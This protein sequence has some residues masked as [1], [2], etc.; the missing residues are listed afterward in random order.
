[1]FTTSLLIGKF[2]QIHF[3][4]QCQTREHYH[5]IF[6]HIHTEIYSVKSSLLKFRSLTALDLSDL[7]HRVF[8]FYFFIFFKLFA[9]CK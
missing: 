3:F 8:Y 7:A 4:V 5:I 6:Y 2:E 9:K 1:M